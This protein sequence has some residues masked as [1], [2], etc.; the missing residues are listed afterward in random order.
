MPHYFIADANGLFTAE[1]ETS[2]PVIADGMDDTRAAMVVSSALFMAI[3]TL[4]EGGDWPTLAV[5][6]VRDF[7]QA[8]QRQVAARQLM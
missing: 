3:A 6:T 5:E 2:G 7:M 1:I 4:A 8:M